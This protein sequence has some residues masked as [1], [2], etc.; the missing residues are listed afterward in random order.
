M[1]KKLIII[2]LIVA[3]A[4]AG[5]IFYATRPIPLGKSLQLKELLAENVA[6]NG[7]RAIIDLRS[8]GNFEWDQL[9][10]L[11]PYRKEI[12]GLRGMEKVF[13]KTKVSANTCILIFSKGN[14][15]NGFSVVPRNIVDFSLLGE[16]YPKKETKFRLQKRPFNGP[17][18]KPWYNVII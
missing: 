14:V 10:I 6:E 2:W 5:I 11:S 1:N 9:Y 8:I 15:I 13:A 12:K 4:L 17:G 18:N 7:K 16:S 3:L